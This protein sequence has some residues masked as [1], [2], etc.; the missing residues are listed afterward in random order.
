MTFD[1]NLGVIAVQVI[2]LLISVFFGFYIRT[3][4]NKLSKIDTNKD[5]A[6]REKDA[7]IE[8]IHQLELEQSHRVTREEV[9]R[10][11]DQTIKPL[12]AQLDQIIKLLGSK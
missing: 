5:E 6:Q 11:I 7:L 3:V 10:M 9:A 12:H 1:I 4:N 8:R 2:M